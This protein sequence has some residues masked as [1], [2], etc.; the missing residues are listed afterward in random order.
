MSFSIVRARGAVLIGAGLGLAAV[1]AAPE[2]HATNPAVPDNNWRQEDRPSKEHRRPMFAAEVRFAPYW[3]QV[4]DEF[5]TDKGP[6]NK[7][8]GDKPKFYFGLEFDYLP[9]RIPYVGMIGPG[10]GW[11]WTRSSA[12]AKIK[13]TN[14]D[15]SENTSLTVMPM[16]LSVVARF[17]EL[18]HRTG[19]PIVPYGKFGVGLAPWSA[20][21]S[22]GVSVYGN[23][24]PDTPCGTKDVDKPTCT[25]GE[26]STWGLHLALGAMFS[27]NWL[28]PRSSGLL[29]EDTDIAHIYVFGEWMDAILNGLGSDTALHVGTS[30]VVVGLA[31]DF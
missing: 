30:T 13:G 5:D 20:A 16:H 4:D 11:G 7:V 29:Y 17:D 23:T 3:P 24:A 15:S 1:M 12:K 25:V 2:A 8:F 9:L 21:T 14:K 28:D 18:M 27:L 26:G 22:K 19:I 31:G 6:Y 10:F